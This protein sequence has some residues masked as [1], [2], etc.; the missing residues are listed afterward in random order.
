MA[1]AYFVKTFRKGIYFQSPGVGVRMYSAASRCIPSLWSVYFFRAP[2][3]DL[4]IPVYPVI[5]LRTFRG[6]GQMTML[7]ISAGRDI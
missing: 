5:E 1:I 7:V 4:G 2:F 6:L 3:Q